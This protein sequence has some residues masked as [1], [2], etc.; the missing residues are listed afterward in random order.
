M[1]KVYDGCRRDNI[2]PE[3]VDVGLEGTSRNSEKVRVLRFLP[4]S[5]N[6]IK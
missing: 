6:I 3:S 5:K 2:L 4:D 1:L